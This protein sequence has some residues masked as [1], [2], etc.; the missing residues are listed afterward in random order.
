MLE[1]ISFPVYQES[2]AEYEGPAA[3]ADACRGLGCSGIEAVWGGDSAV[4]ALPD[5]FAPG[6][7]LTFYPDWVD[8]WRGDEEALLQKFG[9]REAWTAFYGGADRSALIAQYRAD[10]ARAV[11]LGARYVVF[12]VSDVSLEEGYTYRWLHSDAEVFSAALELINLLF[13]ERN[14]PFALLVENQWWPGLTM[15]DP[16]ETRFLLDGIRCENKG[17]LL[18]TGHFMNTDSSLKTEADGIE[19]LHRMLDAHGPLCAAIRGMHLH[20]SLSGDYVRTHTGAVPAALTGDYVTRFG[21]S[22]GHILQIDRHQPWTDPDIVSVI[23]RIDP[24]WLTHELSCKN[25]AE[26]ERVVGIQKQTLRKGGLPSCL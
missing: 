12:H 10:L 21:K 16:E 18:D 26:R 17:V 3:L 23:R 19:S 25:R 14:Y 22:Y 20:Q 15:K 7:H 1:T 13:A 4:D 24:A 2:M 8:F 5:G 9:S 6:Y 11:R